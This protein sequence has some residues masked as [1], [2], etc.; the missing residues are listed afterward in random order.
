MSS[1]AA[2]SITSA[3]AG[4]SKGVRSM[5]V[6]LTRTDGSVVSSTARADTVG[7]AAMVHAAAAARLRRDTDRSTRVGSARPY[8]LAGPS[9]CGGTPLVCEAS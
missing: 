4:V 7:Q 2:P 1:I 9:P 6:E 8:F 3:E 5:G